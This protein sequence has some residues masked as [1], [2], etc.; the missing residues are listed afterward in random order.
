MAKVTDV[1]LNGTIGNVVFYRRMGTN[2]ARSRALHVNQSAA[3]KI[4][5]ANF[6]IA[7]RAGCNPGIVIR[8]F[9]S[10]EFGERM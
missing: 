4:R 5:S 2:C 6:G 8:K 1:F 7:A 10:H 3:T 9:V